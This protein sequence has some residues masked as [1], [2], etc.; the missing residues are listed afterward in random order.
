MPGPCSRGS[1]S[2]VESGSWLSRGRLAHREEKEAQ[3]LHLLEPRGVWAWTQAPVW[4]GVV[5]LST[6]H[7]PHW[8]VHGRALPPWSNQCLFLFLQN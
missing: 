8:G 1:W 5:H 2:E 4:P 3:S 7:E 6:G